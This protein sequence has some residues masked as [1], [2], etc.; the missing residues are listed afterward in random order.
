VSARL[1]L[2]VRAISM[3]AISRKKLRERFKRPVT[4]LIVE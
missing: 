2:E 3:R 4:D 1:D